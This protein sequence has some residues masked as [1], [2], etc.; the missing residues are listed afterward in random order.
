MN[1]GGTF[2]K[3]LVELF[4]IFVWAGQ[5]LQSWAEFKQWKYW[6][7]IR[8]KFFELPGDIHVNIDYDN[9][10]SFVQVSVWYCPMVDGHYDWEREPVLNSKYTREEILKIAKKVDRKIATKEDEKNEV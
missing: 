1:L 4:S 2:Y 3:F 5:K 8:Y 6:N 7:D 10:G 9:K